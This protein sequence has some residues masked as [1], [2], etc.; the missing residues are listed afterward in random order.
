MFVNAIISSQPNCSLLC[1]ILQ[2]FSST[3]GY[4]HSNGGGREALDS[5]FAEISGSESAIVR[6]QARVYILL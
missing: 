3:T 5:I 6:S 2:H 1:K 4:G